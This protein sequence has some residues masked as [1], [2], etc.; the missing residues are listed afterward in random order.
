[1][2]LPESA[3]EFLDFALEKLKTGGIIH[4]YAFEIEEEKE[5]AEKLKNYNIKILKRIVCGAYSARINRVCY[6]LQKI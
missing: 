4:L 2:N 6:D 3:I 1:M 5:I